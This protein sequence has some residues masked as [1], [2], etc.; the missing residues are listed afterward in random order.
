VHFTAACSGC[1]DVATDQWSA[2]ANPIVMGGVHHGWNLFFRGLAHKQ[3]A[4]WILVDLVRVKKAHSACVSIAVLKWG[5]F[6]LGCKQR[7]EVRKCRFS[8][9]GGVLVSNCQMRVQK[10]RS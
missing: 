3:S 7:L 10:D 4:D 6:I 1:L 9:I 2:P 8:V 5:V